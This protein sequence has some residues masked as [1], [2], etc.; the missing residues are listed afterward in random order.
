MNIILV[1]I[2][3]ENCEAT[4]ILLQY[5]FHQK[6]TT[7]QHFKS[8][9]HKSTAPH[10]FTA[11]PTVPKPMTRKIT[12]KRGHNLTLTCE[13]QGVPAP[14]IVWRLNW[15][16]VGPAPRVTSRSERLTPYAKYHQLA[17]TNS[18]LTISRLH[19][20]DEGAYSCEAINS[21]GSTFASPDTVVI[22]TGL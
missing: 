14:V 19:S 20:E 22:V 17:T 4:L 2:T 1:A 13:A 11:P 3:P 12:G 15:G 16:H 7:S 5:F 6:F 9:Y 10:P 8:F 21:L 18:V